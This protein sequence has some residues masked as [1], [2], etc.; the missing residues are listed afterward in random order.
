VQGLTEIGRV[1]GEEA[2]VDQGLGPD[3]P[4]ARPPPVLGEGQGQPLRGLGDGVGQ[5]ADLASRQPHLVQPGDELAAQAGQLAAAQKL[6]VE[7]VV[8]ALPVAQLR[9]VVGL[10][11][12]RI[13]GGVPHGQG[14][15]AE[16]GRHLR[17]QHAHRV[18]RHPPVPLG[19]PGRRRPGAARQQH[20]DARGSGSHRQSIR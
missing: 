10:P 12:V 7:I 17:R 19:V 11:D 16:E 9:G 13:D 5:E 2:G 4:V 8:R 3:V 14:L 18:G 1:V 15:G 20:H 6:G